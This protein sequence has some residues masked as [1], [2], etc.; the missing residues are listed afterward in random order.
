MALL[1]STGYCYA[2]L[3]IINNWLWNEKLK[4][5]EFKIEW[6]MVILKKILYI[7]A[8]EIKY[9]KNQ[10]EKSGVEINK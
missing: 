3:K 1:G 10:S 9:L 5:F 8:R 6:K 4:A 2:T 7:A